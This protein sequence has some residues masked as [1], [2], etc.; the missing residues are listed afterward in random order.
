MHKNNFSSA[1]DPL[2]E[3]I[4]MVKDKKRRARLTYILGQLYLKTG[5]YEMAYQAFEKVESLK[6][7]YEMTFNATLNKY[8]ASIATNKLSDD[9]LNSRLNKML[10]DLKNEEYKDQIYFMLADINL[11]NNDITGAIKTYKPVFRLV[12]KDRPPKPKAI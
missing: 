1:I 4:P 5:K 3:A 2:A 7:S 11:R 8:S 12:E 10:K 6:P 9:D